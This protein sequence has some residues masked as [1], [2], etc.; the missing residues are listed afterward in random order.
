MGGKNAKRDEVKDL[1]ESV[2]IDLEEPMHDSKVEGENMSEP[3]F[4]VG[5]QRSGSTL[6]R[7]L[8]DHHPAINIFGEFEG[9]VSETQGTSWPEI[10]EYRDFL[11][12]D[13]MVKGYDLSINE[14]LDYVSLVQDLFQQLAQRTDKPIVGA[15]V[16]SRIDMLPHIWP[17]ARYIHLLRDPRDVA[18]SCIGMG[19]VGNVYKGVP[20][21]L[22]P[23]QHWDQLE[24]LVPD[25]NIL[26]VRYEELVADPVKTVTEICNFLEVQYSPSMLEIDGDTTYANPDPALAAQWKTKLTEKELGWVECQCAEF[27]KK[28]GY[29]PFHQT[30]SPPGL[31]ERVRI[32]LQSRFYR[33]RFNVK[34][35][36]FTYWLLY[37]ITK[38]TGPK[39]LA[40]A[41]RKR[42][43]EFTILHLK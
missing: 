33:V 24:K 37:V 25:K 6:L 30:L 40:R 1:H 11:R 13:W 23:E 3:V 9:A 31:V 5:A 18:R 10:E 35:W 21:W 36:G 8:M 16:H 22:E 20:F 27:M 38:R 42:I 43:D 41:V 12:H 15:A 4:I 17:R 7:L 19:W 14:E 2:S 28:R 34:R 29:T 39:S 32:E 26:T